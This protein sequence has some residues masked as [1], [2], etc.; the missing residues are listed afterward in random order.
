MAAKQLCL[1]AYVCNAILISQ[2]AAAADADEPTRCTASRPV[3]AVLYTKPNA[4]ILKSRIWEKA[5][6][7]STLIFQDTQISLKLTIE[8][9]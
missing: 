6:E 7:V 2:S 5:P 1:Y 4:E 8:Q 3:A 9:I